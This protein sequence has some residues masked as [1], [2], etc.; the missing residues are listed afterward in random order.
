MTPTEM[1]RR[2]MESESE[3]DEADR[4]ASAYQP[5]IPLGRAALCLDCEVIYEATGRRSCP[6]CGSSAAWSIGHALNRDEA[7]RELHRDEARQE[8]PAA[9]NGNVN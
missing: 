8:E 1:F 9:A 7:R 6:S 5:A 2:L 3:T 4:I